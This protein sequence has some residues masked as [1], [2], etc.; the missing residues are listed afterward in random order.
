MG[1][2]IL[3]F[4]MLLNVFTNI[5][6]IKAL[7]LDPNVS[8]LIS[9][10]DEVSIPLTKSGI[11]GYSHIYSNVVM[12]P[13][14]IYF[15]FNSFTKRSFVLFS[16]YSINLLTTVFVIYKAQYTIA[17][18]LTFFILAFSVYNYCNGVIR[19]FGL[20]L[21][22]CYGSYYFLNSESIALNFGDGKYSD[23]I[24]SISSLIYYG[25]FTDQSNQIG[26][27]TYLYLNSLSA[28]FQN[29]F[30]V[31]VFDTK[32]IGGHSDFIDKFAQ[33]GFIVAPFIIYSFIWFPLYC[34]RKAEG[35]LRNI[36]LLSLLC[37]LVVSLFNTLSVQMAMY[38]FILSITINESK[39]EIDY[40]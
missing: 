34:Y 20:L 16:I 38:F 37:L 27:R 4:F 6:T 22:A 13:L 7:I 31:Q 17:L 12:L 9:R 14:F 3:I 29:P 39:S 21:I 36:V 5:I 30:G 25:N 11:G 40:S 28:F 1:I 15:V 33:F 32:I 23:K 18:L 10:S 19:L 26:N 24:R 2:P 35:N 8:R